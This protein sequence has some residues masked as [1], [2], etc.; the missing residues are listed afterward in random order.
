MVRPTRLDY[1]QYLLSTPINY[2][3]T[4]FA[5]HSHRFSHDQINRYLSNDRL[6]PRHVWEHV[7]PHLEQT[8]DGCLVFDDTVL[9]KRYAKEMVSL[10][11]QQYSGNAGKTINGIG[12][13]TCVYVNRAL[14]RYWLIDYRIYDKQGDGKSKLDH[15]R[16]MLSVLVNA[17]NVA[18][19]T[20]LMD[21]WYASK[22]LLLYIESLDKTYYCPLKSNRLVDDANGSKPYQRIDTLQWT[23]A[24]QTFGKRVKL[25]K[26]P[27][28]HKVKVFRVASSRRTDYVVTNDLSQSDVSVVRQVCD[29]RWKIEQFHRE[30][31]Q[32]T[33]LEKC[34][35]RL[36]RIVR[37]HIAAAFL[38]WVHLMRQAHE[39]GQ[40]LYQL[41]HGL[42]SEYLYQQLKSPMLKINAA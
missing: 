28:N 24:E 20:V 42:L 6:R 25:N 14:D 37:N 16:D 32:L 31:K 13:V 7:K 12:I 35:C 17:R 3:L 8:P 15:V 10:A 9:D 27:K 40:T 29:V 41:K 38:V 33:G 5:D 11:K 2:T 4:H 23:A 34:Q 39:M 26:F 21:S 30:A 22:S 1:C 36:A 19:S 18:F